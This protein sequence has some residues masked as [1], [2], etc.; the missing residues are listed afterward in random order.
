M[1]DSIPLYLDPNYTAPV[2]TVI[3][4]DWNLPTTTQIVP[5]NGT[6]GDISDTTS[7][8]VTSTVDTVKG[9]ATGIGTAVGDFAKGVSTSISSAATT[10]FEGGILLWVIL[11]ASVALLIYT[12]GKSGAIGQSAALVPLFV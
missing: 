10:V 9:T 4:T 3:N 7:K 11:V 8:I 1:S 12:T 2:A 6:W 5:E